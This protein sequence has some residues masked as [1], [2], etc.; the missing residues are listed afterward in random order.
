MLD[1]PSEGFPNEVL[2]RETALEFSTKVR[3][4]LFE[5]IGC[6]GFAACK[7][8]AV[9]ATGEDPSCPAKLCGQVFLDKW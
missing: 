8:A 9:A 4:F 7:K 2:P 6:D 1:S 5:T 3:I